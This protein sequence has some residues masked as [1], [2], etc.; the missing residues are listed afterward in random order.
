MREHLMSGDRAVV[1]R[2]AVEIAG[3]LRQ[4]GSIPAGGLSECAIEEPSTTGS[5]RWDTILATGL[6]YTIEQIGWK[7]RHG[8]VLTSTTY[9]KPQETTRVYGRAESRQISK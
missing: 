4:L 5:Q 3:R 8:F 7:P 9:F 1:L 6:A 2:D